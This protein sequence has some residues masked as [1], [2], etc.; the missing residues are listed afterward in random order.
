MKTTKGFTVLFSSLLIINL[1]HASIPQTKS[2]SV[3]VYT[4]IKAASSAIEMIGNEEKSTDI[5]V[6][7][8][9]NVKHFLHRLTEHAPKKE[10]NKQWKWA[11]ALSFLGLIGLGGLHRLYLGYTKEG[12]A[13]LL[14]FGGLGIWQIIDISRIFNR[15]LKP[16]KG[17]YTG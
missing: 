8:S 10:A 4:N 1:L 6:N 3:E 5:H 13:Q 2:L 15:D 9:E 12:L 7:N 14:T 16:K 11:L 17:D